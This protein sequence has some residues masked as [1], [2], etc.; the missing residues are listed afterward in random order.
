VENHGKL[1]EDGL[2]LAE[3]RTEDR[4]LSA[5][6]GACYTVCA[7]FEVATLHQL[8]RLVRGVRRSGVRSEGLGLGANMCGVV[9][10]CVCDHIREHSSCVGGWRLSV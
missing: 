1:N 7:R 5:T 8:L 4:S 6:E 3:I 9:C 2:V 10:R